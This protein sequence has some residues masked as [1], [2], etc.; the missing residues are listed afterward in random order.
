MS[1]D[2]IRRSVEKYAPAPR[3]SKVEDL[4][5]QFN[6]Y[7]DSSRKKFSSRFGELTYCP[8]N[9]DA[10]KLPLACMKMFNDLGFLDIIDEKELARFIITVK[11]AYRK[12]HYHNWTHAFA[13]AH[14]CYVAIENLDL[15]RRIG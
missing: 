9:V 8:R 11:Y 6:E 15:I 7:I 3:D 13:T 12:N 5:S 14:F 4:V 2:R 1:S 10:A